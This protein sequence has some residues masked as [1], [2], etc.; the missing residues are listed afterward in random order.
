MV[1][2]LAL[3]SMRTFLLRSSVTSMYL[4]DLMSDGQVARG[5]GMYT[6]LYLELWIVGVAAL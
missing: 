3:F 5:A 4:N 6:E 1:V 2:S